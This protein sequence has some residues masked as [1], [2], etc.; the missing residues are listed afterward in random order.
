[1]ARLKKDYFG[2][3]KLKQIIEMCL[4]KA[5][6]DRNAKSNPDETGGGAPAE[7]PKD[8]TASNFGRVCQ[9]NAG[10]RHI[11]L[12]CLEVGCKQSVCK[13]QGYQEGEVVQRKTTAG[14]ASIVFQG[15]EI[16]GG[17]R[18]RRKPSDA[19]AD[20]DDE[21]DDDRCQGIKMDG[22]RCKMKVRVRAPVPY[23]CFVS[24]THVLSQ[25]RSLQHGLLRPLAPST[26]LLPP[27][28]TS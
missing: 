27:C 13:H 3:S 24:R 20:S 23:I 9:Q 19:A 14:G 2:H 10:L 7:H 15:G 6:Y 4:E 8:W 26:T 28:R 21:E 5:A 22:S 16:E 12:R 1:M 18:R 11:K 17:G 25:I